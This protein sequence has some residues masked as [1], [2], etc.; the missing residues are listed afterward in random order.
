MSRCDDG[1]PTIDI[2]PQPLM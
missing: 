1:V 2:W